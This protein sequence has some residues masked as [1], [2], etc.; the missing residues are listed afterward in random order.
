MRRYKCKVYIET[1]PTLPPRLTKGQDLTDH[2]VANRLFSEWANPR[3]A[4]VSSKDGL[5][6]NIFACSE[7]HVFGIRVNWPTPGRTWTKEEQA[8]ANKVN[9]GMNQ[10]LAGKFG[11]GMADALA[12]VRETLEENRALMARAAAVNTSP[13]SNEPHPSIET[14]PAGDNEAETFR[15]AAKEGGLSADDL[16]AV[17]AARG[18]AP[19]EALTDF[20][21]DQIKEGHKGKDLK[22]DLLT[23]LKFLQ[24][25][26]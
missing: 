3:S 12:F 5:N 4:E 21:K 15:A 23:F 8:L 2:V 11:P 20:A 16:A 7:I 9:V 10:R 14:P 25:K 26:K 24:E 13:V 1:R 19:Y 17:L 6:I 22:D 18:S